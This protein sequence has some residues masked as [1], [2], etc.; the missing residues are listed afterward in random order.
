LIFSVSDFFVYKGGKSGDFEKKEE[1]LRELTLQ[2]R[3]MG[4]ELAELTANLGRGMDA[5]DAADKIRNL[6]DICGY[7]THRGSPL[8]E[9]LKFQEALTPPLDIRFTVLSTR[10][11]TGRFPF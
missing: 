9:S 3:E 4:K 10:I 5:R 1:R 6:D 7:F 11:I 8:Q 2:Y